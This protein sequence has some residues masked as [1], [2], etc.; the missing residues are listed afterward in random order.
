MKAVS[1]KN[2]MEVMGSALDEWMDD[3]MKY[4]TVVGIMR[5]GGFIADVMWKSGICW[6]CVK[7]WPEE[8]GRENLSDRIR[9][10]Y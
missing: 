10:R 2:V 5:G 3:D 9:G 8:V 7:V 4:D 1:W 6:N